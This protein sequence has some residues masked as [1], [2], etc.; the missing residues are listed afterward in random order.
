M[1]FREGAVTDAGQSATEADVRA[2]LQFQVGQEDLESEG[3]SHEEGTDTHS[4]GDLSSSSDIT[5]GIKPMESLATEAK[6]LP[7][8]ALLRK[9][10]LLK[11]HQDT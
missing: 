3:S 1:S 11:T 7:K 4:L 2:R 10:L 5:L 6:P 9:K 8:N